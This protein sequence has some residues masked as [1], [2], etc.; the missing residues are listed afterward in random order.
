MGEAPPLPQ[1]EQPEAFLKTVLEFLATWPAM[2]A[3]REVAREEV[4]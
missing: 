2:A 3:R 4:C 1:L